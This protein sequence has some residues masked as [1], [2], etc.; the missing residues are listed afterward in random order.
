MK[1]EYKRIEIPVKQLIE[2][3]NGYGIEGWAFRSI[4][5]RVYDPE[6]DQETD[7]VILLER[8][9]SYA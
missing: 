7:Y 8:S 6:S 1:H 4:V 2:Q 3:L 9:S 5:D